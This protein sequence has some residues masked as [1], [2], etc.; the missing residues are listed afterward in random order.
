MPQHYTIELMRQ[1]K[2]HMIIVDRQQLLHPGFYPLLLF[3]CSA[4][5][6]VPVV[7]TVI[8][9]VGIAAL[10]TTASVEVIAE[11]SRAALHQMV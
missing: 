4:T 10:L 5:G 6:T 7:T 11:G 8:L 2:D 9:I 1:G 3:E